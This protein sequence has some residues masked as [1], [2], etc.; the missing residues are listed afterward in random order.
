[1]VLRLIGELYQ[2]GIKDTGGSQVYE[3][4]FRESSLSGLANPRA[5]QWS[6]VDCLV[7]HLHRNVADD[8]SLGWSKG[9]VLDY[10]QN[11]SPLGETF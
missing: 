6:L 3:V 2:S 1:L 7:N 10:S 8:R 9:S 11:V 4:G 5:F